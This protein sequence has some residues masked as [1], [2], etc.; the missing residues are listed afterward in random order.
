M[1]KGLSIY[2]NYS[3][4]YA[5]SISLNENSYKIYAKEN[6]T[7]LY[8]ITPNNDDIPVNFTIADE[9]IASFDDGLIKGIIAGNTT[10]QIIITEN[11]KYLGSNATI[12][13]E[14]MKID[15]YD[16]NIS[17]DVNEVILALPEDATG[18]V[19][20]YVNGELYETVAVENGEASTTLKKPGNYTVGS[21]R[22]G[23]DA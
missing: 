2:Y 9:S 19:A 5:T 14:V 12:T 3:I 10:A 13:V 11:D 22:F 4:K 1:G 20:V 7:V 23:T 6:I 15:E 17:S 18:N 21:V 16:A 8:E